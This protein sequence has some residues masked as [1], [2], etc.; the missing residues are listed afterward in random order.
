MDKLV[1]NF[2]KN[3]REYDEPGPSVRESNV[4]WLL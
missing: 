4:E 1:W 3:G 2:D